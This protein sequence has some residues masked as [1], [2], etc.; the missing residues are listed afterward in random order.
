MRVAVV[1]IEKDGW[2][3]HT[4]EVESTG[5]CV[6][7]FG[8]VLLSLE[9][10]HVYS[11]PTFVSSKKWSVSVNEMYQLILIAAVIMVGFAPK[12]MLSYVE[13]KPVSTLWASNADVLR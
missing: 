12:G 5:P 11:H 13:L 9:F 10:T 6:R 4:L 7:Y 3:Q 8:M 2:I 1:Q